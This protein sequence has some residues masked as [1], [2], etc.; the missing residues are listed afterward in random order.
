MPAQGAGSLAPATGDMHLTPV[1]ARDGTRLA[2]HEF[3]DRQAA[4]AG[5]L[6]VPAMSVEQSYYAPFAQWLAQQGYLAMTF[7]YRGCGHSRNGSLR[8]E[9]AD[10]MT[11]AQNDTA[12]VVDWASERLGDRPLLWVG[13]SLGG[14]ILGLLPNAHKIAAM[15][16]VATGSGY[17]REYTPGLRRVAPL[18]WYLIVPALLP[19]FGYFPGRRLNMIGDVPAGVMRQWR[20]WCLHPEYLFGVEDPRWRDTYAGLK[21]PILSL[22]FTDDEYMSDRNIESLHGYYSGAARTMR[23]IAPGEVG[24]GAIGHFGFFRRRHAALWPIVGDWLAAAVQRPA[25]PTMA[26]PVASRG[27]APSALARSGAN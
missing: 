25:V 27:G 13:H 21:Q 16:T 22:S 10:V 24:S 26:E 2:A 3:G 19:L 17:W 18:L 5:V 11:W 12:G 8:D 4:R 6:I 7:D 23:R 15:A 9:P 20:S 1:A 14:Q